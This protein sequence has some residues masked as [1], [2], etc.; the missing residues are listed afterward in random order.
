MINV[1]ELTSTKNLP[2]DLSTTAEKPLKEGLQ[3]FYKTMLQLSLA[4]ATGPTSS[5]KITVNGREYDFST[6]AKSQEAMINAQYQY[7]N[8]SQAMHF[9]LKIES[10]YYSDIFK[11]ASR[12]LG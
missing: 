10:T 9:L 3:S 1:N 12:I 4:I 8:V 6:P 7:D 11:E 2:Y 5:E